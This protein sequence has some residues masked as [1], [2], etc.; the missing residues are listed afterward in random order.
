MRKVFR[1][2]VSLDGF[3]AAPNGELDWH[4]VGDDFN[5]HV[6]DMLG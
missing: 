5:R 6:A 3:M 2:M 1:R 4:V